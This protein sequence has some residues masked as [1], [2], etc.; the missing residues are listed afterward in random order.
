MRLLL[1]IVLTH[2]F[3]LLKAQVPFQPVPF[4][5]MADKVVIP[6]GLKYDILFRE[7]EIVVNDKGQKA[8]SKGNH[9][10]NAFIPKGES[11]DEGFFYVSHETNDTNSVAGDGGG[12]TVFEVKRGTNGWVVTSDYH[13]IDFSPVGGTYQNCSGTL[14]GKGT[15]L[16]TEEF[17]PACNADLIKKGRGFRDTSVFNGL[18]RCDNMGWVV[19]VDPVSRKA[20]NKLYSLGRFSHEGILVMPDNKTIFLCDDYLPSVFFRFIADSPND[21]TSGQ[22]Y[23]FRNV[24]QGEC[25][26]W[27]K[28]P[29]VMDSLKRI[30]EVALNMGATA[31]VRMEW[32]TYINKK[33]Y[34]SET[35]ADDFKL[36]SSNLKNAFPSP[37]LQRYKKDNNS[38]DYPYGSILEFDPEFNG[39]KVLIAGGQALKDPEKHFSNPDGL[40]SVKIK[41]KNY[42]VINEDIIALNKGRVSAA[43]LKDN[44]YINEIYWLD[45]SKKN[46]TLDD[47]QRFL[48]APPGAETTGGAFTPDGETYFVNIQHPDL[49]NTPPFNKSMTIA[50]SG[51]AK[52]NK[53]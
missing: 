28:L 25:G 39:M 29:M 45:L 42:L 37:H 7:G 30:R 3:P 13:V 32:I 23:A 46:P 12:G 17:P 6:E 9:D 41:G 26:A 51:L 49:A 11:S 47:L 48:V 27:I 38:Y 8:P 21:F 44:K 4:Q 10:F 33:I 53:K 20:L 50:I 34:I 31:F 2:L 16:T 18:S 24:D 36:D 15:I 5:S 35:G 1:I 14:T 40:T 52:K 43:A 22:L 19:E